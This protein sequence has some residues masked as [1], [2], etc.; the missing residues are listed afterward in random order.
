MYFHIHAH[1]DAMK[2]LKA[3]VR[4]NVQLLA[5]KTVGRLSVPEPSTPPTICLN[6]TENPFNTPSNRY[7]AAEAIGQLRLAIANDRRIRPEAVAVTAG[8]DTPVDTLLRTFCIPQRDNIIVADPTDEDYVR[9][10]ILNDIEYR[11]VRL[12][13]AFDISAFQFSNAVNQRTK[14]IILCSP[15][16]PTGNLLDREELLRLAR[17]FDGLVIV[18]ERYAGF[19]RATSLVKDIPDYPNLVIVSNMSTAFASAALEVGYI[20]AQPD[21]VRYVE[22]VLQPHALPTPVIDAALNMLTRRRYDVDKWVKWI[23]DEREK[24]IAA[25]NV[26]PYCRRVYRSDA[27]FILAE[28]DGAKSIC[29]ELAADNI[30]VEDC[31][32]YT[33]CA[34]CIGITIGLNVENN[35]L[36]SRLRQRH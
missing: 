10:A 5:R 34:D 8:T 17:R 13:D 12:N 6:R 32:S 14:A 3:L 15:N 36:L 33:G 24:V 20:I 2:E 19:A 23:L 30:L 29:Q 1:T 25:L 7:P 31:S 16:Y 18:D 26:L 35:A 9:L 22:A 27:N 11:R 21:I 28:M 4:P